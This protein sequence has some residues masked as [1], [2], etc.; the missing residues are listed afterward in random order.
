MGI[1]KATVSYHVRRLGG[2]T[3]ERFGRR[4][5]WEAVQRYYD[6]GH[7]VRD[8]MKAF[9]FS[10]ASWSDAVRRGAVISRPSAT[11]ISELLVA[12]TYRGRENLKLRLIREGLKENR[13]DHCGLDEWRSVKPSTSRLVDLT[14]RSITTS[15]SNAKRSSQAATSSASPLRH[16]LT[17]CVAARFALMDRRGN[18]SLILNQAY[19]ARC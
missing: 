4:Y 17:I 7:S 6:T 15:A 12:G 1:T 18:A 10:S 2:P 3:D 9:G 19:S 13:C 8:C 11:P 16:A 5:D 14:K